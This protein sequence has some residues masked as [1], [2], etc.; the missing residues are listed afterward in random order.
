MRRHMDGYS[1]GHGGKDTEA[2]QE[3]RS[4]GKKGGKVTE[5]W[6][7]RQDE[8]QGHRGMGTEAGQEARSQ[9]HGH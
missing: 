9:R 8:R 6:T 4:R 1:Q 5:A 2:G 3:A 7:L